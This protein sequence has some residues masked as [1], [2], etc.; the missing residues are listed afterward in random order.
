MSCFIP[1]STLTSFPYSLQTLLMFLLSSSCFFSHL[2]YLSG[3]TADEA[4][5]EKTAEDGDK[6]NVVVVEVIVVVEVDVV[7]IEDK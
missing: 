3:S 5:V 2:R 6:V 1:T 4:K 7:V